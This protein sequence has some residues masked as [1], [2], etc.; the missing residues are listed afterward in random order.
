VVLVRRDKGTDAEIAKVEA[1]SSQLN[2]RMH[3]ADGSRLT[4]AFSKDGKQWTDVSASVEAGH[5][6]P[7]DLATRMALVVRGD[8]EP[9][10][11]FAHFR[12]GP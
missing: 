9:R 4:F 12:V 7:W 10:A 2:L 3:V 1:G 8:G 5:L 11:K 6:P